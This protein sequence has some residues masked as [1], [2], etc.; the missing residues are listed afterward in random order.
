MKKIILFLILATCVFAQNR[1]TRAVWVATNFR[2]DWP[3]P[4][5]D[6]TEQ[7]L[8]LD[9]IFRTIKKKN[10]NT[11]YFQTVVKATALYYSKSLP[12]SPY[13]SGFGE[14]IVDY[15]PLRYAVS[16]ARYYGLEIHAWIN[17]ARVF[18][19]DEYEFLDLPEHVTRLHPDWIVSYGSGR[20][21]SY[22]LDLGIPQARTF[23]VNVAKEIAQ[24]YDVDGIQFDFLR[25]PG[26]NFDDTKTFEQYGD[27][28]TLEDWR[29]ENINSFLRD[30]YDSI[31]AIKPLLKLG[32]APF[33]IYKNIP[34][35][36]GGESFSLVYQ[37]SRKW[38]AEGVL[39]Y[40]VPQTY[41]DINENPRFDSLAYDWAKH[42]YGRNIV[43]GVAAYKRDVIS[44]KEKITEIARNAGV[45]GLAFFRY[46]FIEN[47]DFPLFDKFVY[48]KEMPWLDANVPLKPLAFSVDVND[49]FFVLL[50]KKSPSQVKFYSLYDVT[51]QPNI[52][53]L[54]PADA[55]Y[56]RMKITHPK[57]IVNKF[58]LRAVSKL[59]NE[60]KPTK[61]V[62]VELKELEK[63][64]NTNDV[65][66]KKPFVFK[67]GD[68]FFL[69]VYSANKNK[70]R[71]TS[72]KRRAVYTLERGVNIVRLDFHITGNVSLEFTNENKTIKINRPLK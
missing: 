35:A 25:Y 54:F 16:L 52:I 62:T 12:F 17:T 24:N 36:E 22:W 4:V 47:V 13:I 20:D 66:P 39:D 8:A 65:I 64:V 7:K 27:T 72:A 53:S 10:F 45:A 32:A 34:G 59:W 63:L 55:N 19:G 9:E 50:W 14:R 58:Q 11:V 71:I 29:R 46:S 23:M 70:I 33:G 69:V 51:T 48:P 3:P 28:L 61:T 44:Q 67:S 5:Y 42:S 68:E 38:L 49:G 18:S 2:L 31:K 26:K 40:L 56:A 37:D 1:E 57:A 30:A 15:D 6:E 41:W 60:S 21:K 43:L